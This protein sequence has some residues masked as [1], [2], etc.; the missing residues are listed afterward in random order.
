M[1]ITKEHT[2]RL[3]SILS[4]RDVM[5]VYL[6]QNHINGKGFTTCPFH[7]E[8][9]PSFIVHPD[10]YYC[11]GCGESGDIIT[12][13]SKLFNLPFKDAVLKLDADFSVGLGLNHMSMEEMIRSAEAYRKRQAERAREEARLASLKRL[14]REFLDIYHTELVRLVNDKIAYEP[15]LGDES[16]SEKYAEAISEIPRLG[17]LYD[18]WGNLVEA[19]AHE[20]CTEALAKLH[21]ILDVL[22]ADVQGGEKQIE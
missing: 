6:P 19:L 5:A 17:A 12:L 2:D 13:T 3:K 10:R 9:S 20:E 8:K 4:M 16:L 21:V 14:D 22:K 18:E 1:Y 11:F 7:S 15:N